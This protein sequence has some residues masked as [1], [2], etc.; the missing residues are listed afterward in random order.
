VFI[1]V[2]PFYLSSATR[3]SPALTRDA[4][5]SIR[6]RTRA[7]TFSTIVCA[8]L[9]AYVLYEH[10]VSAREVF[11]LL[12]L[13]P[14]SLLDTAQTILLVVILFAGPIFEHG[15]VD[16]A[17]RDWIKLKR[18]YETLSSW[19]GYRNYVVVGFIPRCVVH[20]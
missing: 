4:P 3:P 18:V 6:A 16:G 2:V 12:G 10:D 9:T 20:G 13:W 8:I 1:Y 7:V 5:S 17:W 11:K 15:I 14:V 19:I